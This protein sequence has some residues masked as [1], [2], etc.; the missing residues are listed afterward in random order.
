M[1]SQLSRASDTGS[2]P[3]CRVLLADDSRESQALIQ[4]YLRGLPY[5]LDVVGNGEEAV[6]MFQS[7]QF[8]L[9]LLDQHMPVMDGL[10]AARVMREWEASNERAPVPILTL[11][12]DSLVD[13]KTQA[14]AAGCTACLAKP[15][16]KEQLLDAFR[17]FGAR[18][19]PKKPVVTQNNSPAGMAALIDEEI[20]RRRPL[21]LDHRRQDLKRM[22]EAIEQGDFEAIRIIGHRI[23]GL[24]G[25]YGFHDIGLSGAQLEQAAKDQ[26]IAA[27]RR[28]IDCLTGLL[29]QARQAV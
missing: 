20:T 27:M 25:S 24:A 28:T 26:D 18:P 22:Q 19:S 4:L 16:V 2:E 11:T 13:V 3:I 1:A 15:I 12:A 9:V 23:K 29:A 6:A 21:F 14:Q 17:R 10:T 8:D 7:Q 5:Q